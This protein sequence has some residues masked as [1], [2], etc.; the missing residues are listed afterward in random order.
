MRKAFINTL[1]ELAEK[2]KRIFLL[3]GDLGFSVIERFK[4]KFPDRFFDMGVAEQNM[5]GFSAGLAL[6]G[7]IVFVY[8]IIPFLTMRCFEQIR[9]DLCYQNAN[10]KLIGV[11]AGFAYGSAGAT[12]HAI[13]DIGIMRTLPNMSIIC[14]ADPVETEL[15]IKLAVKYKH[16]IYIRLGSEKEKIYS[17]KINFQFGKGILVKKGKDITII[18]TGDILRNVIE[19][20]R[21]L[22]KKNIDVRIISIPTVKPIDQEIILKSVRET[23]AIFTV[24]EHNIIGGLGSAVAEVLSES[25][26][27]NVIFKRIGVPDKFVKVVGEQ[28]YL[29]EKYNLCTNSILKTILRYYEK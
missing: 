8:S 2:D 5:I 29:R 15:T 25:P 20:E 11:G 18:S 3:T 28:K 16:P 17:R 9:N 12:H 1:I 21:K 24:E 23:K 13:E 10:V 14:P 22:S 7:K 26:N 6:S 19:A 27:K 4:E